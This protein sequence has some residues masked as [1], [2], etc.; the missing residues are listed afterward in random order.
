MLSCNTVCRSNHKI[1]EKICWLKSLLAVCTQGLQSDF[2]RQTLFELKHV[3]YTKGEV[4]A[5]VSDAKLNGFELK[6][7]KLIYVLCV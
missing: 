2:Y 6:F 3:E 1:F 4:V 7:A 5:S